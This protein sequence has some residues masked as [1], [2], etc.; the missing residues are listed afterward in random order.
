MTLIIL[1][2]S[3]SRSS[4]LAQTVR[5]QSPTR[6]TPSM[7]P[8]PRISPNRDRRSESSTKSPFRDH[9]SPSALRE[10]DLIDRCESRLSSSGSER[11]TPSIMQ[12]LSRTC[13]SI[14]STTSRLSKFCHECGSKFP[15]DSA[16]FCID[17]GVRRLMV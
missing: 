3:L 17:C 10:F 11:S 13:S 7:S 6:K 12:P 5:Q 9:I 8:S 14:I 16:K 1:R 15:L 4:P 2:S